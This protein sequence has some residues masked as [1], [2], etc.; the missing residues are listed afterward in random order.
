MYR[1]IIFDLD[2][3]LLNT[4]TD[5]ASSV[6]YA[7]SNNDIKKKSLDEIRQALG[8][9]MLKLI[10]IV[11]EKDSTT[12]EFSKIYNDFLSYYQI[13]S[14]DTTVPY[15]GIITLLQYLKANNYQ[16]AVVS[17]KKD[18][19]VKKLCKLYF[20]G[21]I[22]MVI[23]EQPNLTPKPNQAMIELVLK[24]LNILKT[25]VLYVGDSEVDIETGKNANIDYC[26][27]TW[28]F[29]TAKE[30]KKEGKFPLIDNPVELIQFLEKNAI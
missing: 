23:G 12:F 27:C 3:T 4:L 29:R 11:S 13:H 26:I 16:I 8:N 1:C 18:V 5:L 17:N 20:P 25:S 2:G 21:L 14:M 22:D 30:L 6:N 28:G 19:F 24:K 7:L 9:G 15:D 10:E